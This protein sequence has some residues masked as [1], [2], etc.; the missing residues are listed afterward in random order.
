MDKLLLIAAAAAGFTGVSLGAFGAHALKS[1][2][3]PDLLAIFQTGV[4][5]HLVHAVA[6]LGVAVLAHSSA[7]V[8]ARVGGWLFVA[9]ILVF[10]G[11]LYA[12]ALSGIR[13]LGAV[14]PVGGLCFLAGWAAL[15]WAAI[16]A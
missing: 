11:S 3:A 7:S 15:A 8:S 5:Y 6:L 1:R 2:L 13:A 16:R 14:T 9:G 4:Q 12:L 10:S